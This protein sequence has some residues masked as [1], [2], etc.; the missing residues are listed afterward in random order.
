MDALPPP[1]F[2]GFIAKKSH[3]VSPGEC[4]GAEEICSVAPCIARYPDNWDDDPCAAPEFNGAYCV[5]TAAAAWQRVRESERPTAHVY[6]VRLF[7]AVFTKSSP[8]PRLFELDAMFPAGLPPLPS[9]PDLRGYERL[10]YDVTVHGPLDEPGWGWSCSPL[11]CNYMFQSHPVNRF[12][13]IDRLEDAV[14][15]AQD[16]AQNE[17]EPGPYVIVEVLRG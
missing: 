7:P 13:L 16:F 2:L 12:C 5:D 11:S 15:A 1:V 10:G 6:A 4:G 8:N 9:E 17:P 3:P 14:A